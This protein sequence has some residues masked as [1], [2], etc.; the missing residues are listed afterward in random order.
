MTPEEKHQISVL[1]GKIAHKTG[2]DREKALEDY[3]DAKNRAEGRRGDLTTNLPITSRLR[4]H[5][6]TRAQLL[7]RLRHQILTS[8]NIIK[9]Q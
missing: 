1:R 8:L 2:A 4:Y 6:A 5:C 7:I 3:W 9:M